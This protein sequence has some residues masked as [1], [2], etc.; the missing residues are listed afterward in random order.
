MRASSR[1]WRRGGAGRR[2]IALGVLTAGSVACVQNPAPHG[3]LSPAREMQAD[4]Y[5]AWIVVETHRT[6]RALRGEFLGVARDSVFVLLERGAVETVPIA[7]VK[8]ARIAYFDARWHGLL[9]Y[10][11]ALAVATLSN[12]YG[13]LLTLPTTLVVGSIAT[14]SQSRAPIVDVEKPS[15]FEGVIKYARFPA[16]IPDPLPRALPPRPTR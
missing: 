5:G 9:A 4:Q 1:W 15:A 14:A 6:E 3:W 2:A 11:G 12:G 7:D 8:R 16:G 13:M 10:T